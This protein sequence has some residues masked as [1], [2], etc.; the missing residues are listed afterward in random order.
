MPR[1]L[2]SDALRP[3][4]FEVTRRDQSNQGA[5]HGAVVR[6]GGAPELFARVR[7]LVA[8]NAFAQAKLEPV[9]IGFRDVCHVTV[10]TI[11]KEHP[12]PPTEPAFSANSSRLPPVTPSEIMQSLGLTRHPEGGHYCET[13]RHDA[14][15]LGEWTL[16]GCTVSPAFE[17]EHVE[18]AP[19]GWNPG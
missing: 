7:I 18:L 19:K 9:Q 10:L 5:R 12:H 1:G 15:S 2:R 13:W 8:G 17:F 14:R 4:L 16:V 11:D 3:D 6:V